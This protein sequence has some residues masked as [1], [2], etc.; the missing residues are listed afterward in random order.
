M[1]AS[2]RTAVEGL[3]QHFQ[4][5]PEDGHSEDKPATARLEKGLRCRATGPNG[6]E[7]ISDMSPAVGGSGSAATPGWYLRA[8]LA[9]CDASILA[10]RAAQLGWELS[11][12]E[13]TVE[14]TSDDRAMFD[15]APGVPPGPLE[16]RVTVLLEGPN[17]TD[18]QRKELLDWVAL[19][20]PVADALKRA[21]P[22]TLRLAGPSQ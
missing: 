20:S 22:M 1:S 17:L 6:F 14:S 11:R 13:V 9:N 8:T 19:T 18:A 12:L 21:V 15:L 7:L 3:I 2:I 5:H 4:A 10:L 16:L